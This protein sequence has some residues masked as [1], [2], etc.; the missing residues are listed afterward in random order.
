[1]FV[2]EY[3]YTSCEGKHIDYVSTLNEVFDKVNFYKDRNAKAYV[4]KPISLNIS[5]TETEME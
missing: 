1:M 2:V 3:D 4:L 5:Y